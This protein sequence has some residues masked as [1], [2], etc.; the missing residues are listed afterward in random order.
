MNAGGSAGGIVIL[1]DSQVV[2]VSDSWIGEFSVSAMLEDLA[3]NSKWLITS[4]YGPNYI[5]MRLDFWK[6]LGS[7]NGAWCVGAWEG[8]GMSSDFQARS[9]V[10]AISSQT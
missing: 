5:G 9:W 2:S 1:W 3:N 10:A 4:V 8:T 7:W 6:E